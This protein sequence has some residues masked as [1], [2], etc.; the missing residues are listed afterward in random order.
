MALYTG[1][2]VDRPDASARGDL[3]WALEHLGFEY[4]PLVAE[5]INEETLA[6]YDILIVPDGDAQEIV[7]GWDVKALLNSAPWELPG[8]PRG[9]GQQGIDALRNYVE[10]GGHYLG[11]GS[12]GGLLA[13]TQYANLIS[14]EV[15]AHSL[16]SARVLLRVEETAHPLLSGLGGYYDENGSWAEGFF[17]AQYQSESFTDTPGGPVFRAGKGCSTLASYYTVD[18]DPASPYVVNPQYLTE[19][20]GGV[21]IAVQTVGQGQVAVL[22]VRAGFRALWTNTWKLLS[23][24][25]FLA[26]AGKD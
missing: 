14:L 7:Q 5:D 2:G 8:K 13:S 21:A 19:T 16:G 24:A 15:L 20:E 4:A 3:R 25:I 23:N 6:R 17:P 18:R 12:G 10:A 9:I 1:Q 11:L 26:A 22:G